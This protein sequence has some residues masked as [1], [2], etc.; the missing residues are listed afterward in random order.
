MEDDQQNRDHA[1]GGTAVSRP[2]N[3]GTIVHRSRALNSGWFPVL[4]FA[5]PGFEARLLWKFE[6]SA[7][8]CCFY[9]PGISCLAL[10]KSEPHYQRELIPRCNVPVSATLTNPQA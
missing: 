2:S 7:A 10:L 6:L 4:V 3:S 9:L 8:F 5:R 1:C